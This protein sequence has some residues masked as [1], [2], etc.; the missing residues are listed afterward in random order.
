MESCLQKDKLQPLVHFLDYDSA[1]V[2]HMGL[3][4]F[5]DIL[6]SIKI[7]RFRFSLETQ[8][9]P[10][11]LCSYQRKRKRSV[12]MLKLKAY[13]VFECTKFH[14][15]LKKEGTIE[16]KCTGSICKFYLFD[17]VEDL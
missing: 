1:T 6:D 15:L 7:Y 9:M 12:E 13:G 16:V 10:T 4:T 14:F 11:F 17:E 3:Q 8:L 2:N 5:L